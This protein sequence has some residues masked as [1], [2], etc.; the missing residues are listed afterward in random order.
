MSGFSLDLEEASP[1]FNGALPLSELEKRQVIGKPRK[2]REKLLFL[3][4][5]AHEI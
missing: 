2:I 4:L 5:R 3:S 1:E